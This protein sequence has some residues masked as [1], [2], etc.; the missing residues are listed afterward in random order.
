MKKGVKIAA[1]CAA[2][3]FVFALSACAPR[4]VVQA[5]YEA[6]IVVAPSAK[7][8]LPLV[9][10][11]ERVRPAV[12]D[13]TS[14]SASSASAGSGVIIA[15]ADTDG[16]EGDD[17][18]FIVTNHHVISGGTSFSV[19][20]LTIAADGS[21][22][23]ANYPATLVGSSLTRD[24]AVLS[25]TPPAGVVFTTASFIETDATVKVGTEV[26]AIGN[27]LG[28][29][30]GTVTHGIVSATERNVDVDEIGAMTLMQTD[31]SINGGNPGGGL[32]N[33]EGLIVGII[34]SGYDTYNGQS[35]EGLNFA[36]PAD[37]ARFAATSLID[38]FV[39]ENG[40]VVQYGYVEGDARTDVSFTSGAVYTSSAL[41][42]RATYLVASA[43]STAS[44]LYGTWGN[45][46]KA[47][48][49]ISVNGE[50]TEFTAGEGAYALIEKASALLRTV[51]AGDR[52]E[53]GYYE[54]LS[55]QIGGGF[56]G[57]GTAVYLGD[58]LQKVTFT[59]EQYI[60][61]P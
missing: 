19:D 20:V 37:D 61:E 48:S 55:R 27:P 11:L 58:T 15:G 46:Q 14:V 23:T 32:F 38:T 6:E 28:I 49:Y 33:A 4:N 60:Y 50:K 2:A 34:N 51:R 40:E 44:P 36:I 10:M 17:R 3:V 5:R 52:V 21:E 26:Y 54:L 41:T 42:A 56:F 13:V 53:I 18:Y 16:D 9:E 39:E 7:E 59:A 30:G 57:G 29:L 43:A 25:V 45:Y 47:V 12:V 1:I 35:V 8:T 22:S 31:A 24:I